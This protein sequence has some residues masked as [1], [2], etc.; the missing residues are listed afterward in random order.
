L[1]VG[2]HMRDKSRSLNPISFVP[3]GR[4]N[5]LLPFSMIVNDENGSEILKIKEII[6]DTTNEIF[7]S[8][9]AE[10]MSEEITYIVPA[11]WGKIR[12]GKLTDTQLE[13]N[14]KIDDVITD[15]IQMLDLKD[16]NDLQEFAFEYLV[17]GLIIS[18]I[19][20]LIEASKH[21]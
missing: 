9:K 3:L 5:K 16:L 11:V 12:H 1:N 19:T 10:F 15:I 7:I 14:G 17:R 2:R 21:R 13:I 4:E 20:Y 6:D 8:H 18:K